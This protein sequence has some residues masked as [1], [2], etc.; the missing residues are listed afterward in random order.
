MR[1]LQ[2]EH[3]LLRVLNAID[4][5]MIA[6]AIPIVPSQLPLERLDIWVMTRLNLQPVETLI[7]GRWS[8]A[9]AR[10][11]K[12]LASRLNST[13]YIPLVLSTKF[14]DGRRSALRD[15]P[16]RLG[17]VLQQPGDF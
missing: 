6:D 11:K 1:D 13:C 3:R 9:L 17:K 16:L 4:H 10:S 7:Q 2:H 12:R 8:V 5:P 15:I 14:F